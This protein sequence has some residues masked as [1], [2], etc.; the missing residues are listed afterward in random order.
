M[1]ILVVQE[2]DW[3]KRG[4]HQQHHLMER[5]SLRGHQIRVIDY[6]LLWRK[7]ARKN[8]YSKRQVLQ[9]ISKVH[10]EANITL[11]RPAMVKIPGLDYLSLIFS[12]KKEI[13]RQVKKFRPEIIVGFGILNTY[14]AMKLAKKNGISFIYYLIDVLHTL[15][16]VRSLRWVAKILEKKTL[17]NSD[18][19]IVINDKLKDYAIEMGSDPDRTY[20]VR[21]GVDFER[22][23]SHIDGSK[24]RKQYK[25]EESDFVLFFMGWLYDFSGL[26]EVTLDLAKIKKKESNLKV[27]IVGEGDLYAELKKIRQKYNLQ[28]RIILTGWQ[29]YEK[30][31]E[32][33]KISDLC[34]FP[35]HDNEVTH[36]IVPIK[37]YEYM[38]AGKPVIATRLPGVVKE[39]GNNNGVIYADE[40]R[41]VV[42][43][44]VELIKNG[45]LAEQGLRA[46]RFVKRYS[47]DNITQDFEAILEKACLNS[48]GRSRV[49]EK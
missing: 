5:L 29:P 20:L 9:R 15:V 40:P 28:D 23:N 14:L 44:T 25:I 16:P 33:L 27:L 41:E 19:V 39:F 22:F 12:H 11:L 42:K 24:V 30:I 13:A 38:A 8:L 43:R 26:K 32:F 45:D 47:W 18:G 49:N 4:P 7:E 34:L 17:K 31:P 10:K 3:I 46:K 2:T 37:I 6:Q 36:N 1:K 21:A 48:M 35:A